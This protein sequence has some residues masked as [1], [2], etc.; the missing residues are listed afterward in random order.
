MLEHCILSDMLDE[1][2]DDGDVR[3]AASALYAS[4]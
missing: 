3:D 1:F 2:G 4:K